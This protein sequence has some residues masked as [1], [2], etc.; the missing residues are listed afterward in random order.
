[1]VAL[2]V[3]R[4]NVIAG[5]FENVVGGGHNLQVYVKLSRRARKIERARIVRGSDGSSPA[6]KTASRR[7]P[8]LKV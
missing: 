1:M 3:F 8:D 2:E 4:K 6:R 7:G 5:N